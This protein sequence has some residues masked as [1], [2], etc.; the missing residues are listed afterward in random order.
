MSEAACSVVRGAGISVLR[1]R[2][3]SSYV[4]VADVRGVVVVLSAR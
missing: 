4:G 3:K 2:G 1:S